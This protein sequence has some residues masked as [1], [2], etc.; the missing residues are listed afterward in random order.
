MNFKISGVV[1]TYNS[2]ETLGE[3]IAALQ[4][5]SVPLDEIIV[6][7]DGSTDQ[8]SAIASGWNCHLLKNSTNRGRGYSRNLGI[9]SSISDLVLFCD[10]S[11]VIPPDFA[12]TA[13]RHFKDPLVSAVFGRIR[14]DKRLKD[15]FSRWRG[16]HLFREHLPHRTDVHR[17]NCLITYAVVLRKN[18]VEEVGNFDAKLAKCEDIDLG[19]KLTER[20]FKILSDPALCAYSIRRETMGSICVRFNRWFSNDTDVSFRLLPTFW[21]TLRSCYRIYV[22]EDLKSKDFG[23]LIISLLLPFWLTTIGLLAPSKLN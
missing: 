6:I 18:A 5:Q 21:H 17:V 15:R 16:R 13:I 19:K 9:K 12:E 20:G 23:S 14:N 4:R 11:N 10:S 1:P 8:S 7:D 2:E 3:N 22:W